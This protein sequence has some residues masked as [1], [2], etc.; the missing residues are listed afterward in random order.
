MRNAR[1]AFTL[2]ELLVAVALLVLLAG[3]VVFVFSKS[4]Q[5]F[6]VADARAQIFQNVRAGVD[7][8][9][10]DLMTAE[11]LLQADGTSTNMQR[12]RI[13][14]RTY[15]NVKWSTNYPNDVLQV[16][17]LKA[18]L[19][20]GTSGTAYAKYFLDVGG[21]ASGGPVRTSV[22]GSATWS[23]EGSGNKE[24][25]TL[26]RKTCE[27]DPTTTSTWYLNSDAWDTANDAISSTATSGI[28]VEELMQYVVGFDVEPYYPNA[29]KDLAGADRW[30]DSHW[31][32]DGENGASSNDF[33]DADF[34]TADIPAT[35]LRLIKW[36]P[37]GSS[38]VAVVST[39]FTAGTPT[40]FN[41]SSIP[42][43]SAYYVK[44]AVFA[45]VDPSPLPS[46]S[47]SAANERAVSPLPTGLRF[48]FYIRDE[49]SKEQRAIPQ[50][51]WMPMWGG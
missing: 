31:N 11:P 30:G 34:K 5:V 19:P 37:T 22:A 29:G 26:K 12:L 20:N 25:P 48:T 35:R 39:P 36:D 6:I 14:N 17:K 1:R 10:R 9:R 45:T 7:M 21:P 44:R 3:V 23:G 38:D 2:I 41:I 15:A 51:I 8:M 27:I 43:G 46:L 18:P 24:V 42:D 49:K 28:L 13:E 47:A 4:V 33:M 16:W 32:L 40:V 50:T